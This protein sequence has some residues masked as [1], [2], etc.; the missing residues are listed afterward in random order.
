MNL[1]KVKRRYRDG[2]D[3]GP[4]LKACIADDH[5]VVDF[6][7]DMKIP[8][9]D[10]LNGCILRDLDTMAI[11]LIEAGPMLMPILQQYILH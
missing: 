5:E 6:L 2:C 8:L 10:E 9:T 3:M 1:K 4:L 11:K 7:L